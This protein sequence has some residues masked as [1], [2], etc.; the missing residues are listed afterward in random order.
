MTYA[1][2]AEAESALSSLNN[3]DTMTI[4]GVKR[5]EEAIRIGI[6]PEEMY[7]VVKSSD[8]WKVTQTDKYLEAKRRFYRSN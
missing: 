3:D 6:K 8:G 2:K 5:T 7:E 4:Y 1:T